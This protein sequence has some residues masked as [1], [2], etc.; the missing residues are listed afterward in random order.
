MLEIPIVAQLVEDG[1]WAEL[2]EPPITRVTAVL[3]YFSENG[4]Q[5]L[6]GSDTPSDPTFANPPGL[7]GRIEMDRWVASGV[8]PAQL[9]AA[10]TITNAEFFGLAGEIGTVEVGKRADLL[11]LKENPLKDIAA[12]DTIEY[13]IVGGRVI[14]RS[15][16]SALGDAMSL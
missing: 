8:S 13:V 11:L 15:A 2:D 5:L 10:A 9:F 4:G 1:R 12:Y 3:T 14:E 7:N 6:F 16:L